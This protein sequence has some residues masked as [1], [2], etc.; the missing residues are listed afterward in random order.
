MGIPDIGSTWITNLGGSEKD[1]KKKKDK[2]KKRNKSEDIDDIT[3]STSIPN[4]ITE[5]KK[6]FTKHA[7]GEMREKY[8]NL[9]KAYISQYMP[10]I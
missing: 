1:E 3:N 10:Q 7:T 5:I 9:R 2:K 6:R 4:E 8:W